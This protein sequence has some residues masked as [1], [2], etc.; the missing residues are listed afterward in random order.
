MKILNKRELQKIASNHSSGMEF[1]DFMILYKDYAKEPFF[2][3]RKRSGDP[4][5]FRTNVS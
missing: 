1:K 5:R 4:L 2:I 3:F